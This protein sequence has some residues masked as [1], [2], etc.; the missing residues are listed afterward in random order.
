MGIYIDDCLI[1]A[2][3]KAEVIKLYEDLKSRFEVTNEGPID[4]YLGVKVERRQDRT[5]K[6]SQPLLTQQILDEMGFNHRTKGRTTPALSSQILERD[7]NGKQK[8]TT[9][10]YHSILGKLNYLKKSTRPDLAYAVH[11]CARFAADPKE[12]HIQAMMC[13][14]RYLHATKEKGFIY[15]PKAQ[16]FDLW[17]NADFSGNWSP[18]TAHMDPLTAK[19]RTGFV[20]TFARCPIA[21]ASKLQTEVALSTT[22]AEFIALSEGL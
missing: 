10:N 11:Q 2:P 1:I 9:W 13:I 21:W 3:C 18:A 7:S 5:M 12:S 22:E 4:E 20:I 14:G 16:S 8:L 15:N 17:C 19:S 6:L